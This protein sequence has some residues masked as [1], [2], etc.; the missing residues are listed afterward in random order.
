MA[1]LLMNFLVISTILEALR[2]DASQK[3]HPLAPPQLNMIRSTSESDLIVWGAMI[4]KCPP[5][6]SSS[7]WDCF[8]AT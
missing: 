8:K 7:A 2:T 6:N 1:D 5:D 4:P 3:T